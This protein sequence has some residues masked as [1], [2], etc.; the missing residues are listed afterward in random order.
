MSMHSDK[1]CC[2]G[3]YTMKLSVLSLDELVLLINKIADERQRRI[4]LSAASKVYGRGGAT[5]VRELTGIAF[6]TLQAGKD[7]SETAIPGRIRKAGGGRK[8]IEEHYPEIAEA[9]E[10]IVDGA[11]YGNP[12]KVLHWISSTLCLRKIAE[13]LLVEYGITVSHVKVRQLL[14]E[15][16]YSKQVN[17]KM[18]QVA[19]P[20][21]HRDEQFQIINDIASK[22][23][24][25]DDPAGQQH[26]LSTYFHRAK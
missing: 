11:T 9:L 22:Y 16:G 6:S 24:E 3:E 14:L 12:S 26:L 7:I 1:L 4:L 15:L 5:R 13:R 17:Q 10:K 18:E 2:M 23:I 20:N 21:P 25:S 19:I 8:P